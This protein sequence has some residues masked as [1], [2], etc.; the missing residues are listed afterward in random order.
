MKNLII[1][2]VLILSCANAIKPSYKPN[3]GNLVVFADYSDQEEGVSMRLAKFLNEVQKDI[4]KPFSQIAP[5]IILATKNLIVA[6]KK[7]IDQNFWAIHK[8]GPFLYSFKAKNLHTPSQYREITSLYF[9]R[10]AYLRY[11]GKLPAGTKIST[12]PKAKMP[13]LIPTITHLMNKEN[14]K[15]P[16]ATSLQPAQNSLWNIILFGHGKLAC[17]TQKGPLEPVC[18]SKT[19][20]VII[21]KHV[22]SNPDDEDD[23]EDFDRNL[24]QSTPDI[25]A[26]VAARDFG[27]L[28]CK[29]DRKSV[30]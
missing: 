15:K 7:S 28:L 9:E 2:A 3:R 11:E 1:S 24:F 19:G 20:D 21:K 26:N 5:T 6:Q 23:F 27:K 18:H 14:T 16:T 22:E 30:V 12:P 17:P 10:R 13:S 25:I 8:E 29:L 4:E